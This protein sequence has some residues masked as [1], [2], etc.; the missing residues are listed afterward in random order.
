M[1]D[2]GHDTW[3]N[4][5]LTAVTVWLIINDIQVSEIGHYVK[6]LQSKE[7]KDGK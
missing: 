5:W 4:I 7:T 2:W 1:S 3:I 6:T